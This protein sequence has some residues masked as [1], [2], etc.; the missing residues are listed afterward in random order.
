MNTNQVYSNILYKIVALTLTIL[1]LSPSMTRAEERDSVIV[2]LITCAPG[3][4]VYRLCGHEAIRVRG[5]EVDS[6]W[7]Y[8]LFDFEQ[9]NFVYRFVSGE[10]DYMLGAFPYRVFMLEYYMENRT[11]YEQDLNLTQAEA[12]KLLGMLRTESL[13]ENCTYRYNYVLDNCATRILDRLDEAT[14]RKIIYPDSASYGTFRKVMRHYHR[15]YPWYQF[16]IDLAL[17]SGIDVPITARAE[18]FAP[19]EMMKGAA[20]AEFDDG[21]PLVSATRELYIGAEDATLGPTPAWQSPLAVS[22]VLLILSAL[23]LLYELRTGNIPRWAYS[24]WFF[25]LGI[26][27]CII[28]F[29]VFVSSHE[30]TSPN[31]LLLWLNPLQLIPAITVWWRGLNKVTLS[32]MVYDIIIPMLMLLL[33]PLQMQ[34]GNPAIFPLL[35]VTVL[36][37]LGYAIISYKNSYKYNV[38]LRNNEKVSNNGTGRT[39]KSRSSGTGGRRETQT[40]GRN[41]R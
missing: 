22:I 8:G 38:S 1:F 2:S 19:P 26:A 10:T 9:P 18:M 39:G 16:G 20:G 28:A 33:W 40:R 34:S 36:L 6:V 3:A 31:I 11:V 15:D 13:P 30:A 24:L 29:L 14:D 25:I 17:G 37:A 5:A 21:T 35:G 23:L 41:R 7:N 27:G 32:M 12:H 4:D